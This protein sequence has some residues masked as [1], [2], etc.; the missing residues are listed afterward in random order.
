MTY[1]HGTLREEKCH[2]YVP[3]DLKLFIDP[4][5]IAQNIEGKHL[6][7]LE[8]QTFTQCVW[9]HHAERSPKAW[10]VVMPKEG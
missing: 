3:N 2:Y 5:T 4:G 7:Y 1:I 10:V 8:T 9:L 6:L